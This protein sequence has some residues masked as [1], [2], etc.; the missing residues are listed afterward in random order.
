MRASQAYR[1]VGPCWTRLWDSMSSTILVL[2]VAASS[3]TWP[4]LST[5]GL[6]E[7]RN[8]DR[9]K[10]MYKLLKSQ[11]AFRRKTTKQAT[12]LYVMCNKPVKNIALGDV[13]L[14]SFRAAGKHDSHSHNVCCNFVRDDS[15][16]PDCIGRYCVETMV[17]TV[18]LAWAP[19][20][21]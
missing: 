19:Q 14:S 11:K 10:R 6:E 2:L 9:Y 18:F 17:R 7:L 16:V 8:N 20:R 13:A 3:A 15:S 12:Y 21:Q 5:G 4:A 1:W